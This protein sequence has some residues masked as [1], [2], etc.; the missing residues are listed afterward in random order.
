MVV[1]FENTNN[2]IEVT[3]WYSIVGAP[4]M[5][6]SSYKNKDLLPVVGKI[7]FQDGDATTL[8]LVGRIVKLDGSI[9]ERTMMVPGIYI[10]NQ[11]EWPDWLHDLYKLALADQSASLKVVA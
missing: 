2:K 11:Q 4:V 3:R 1:E 10:W 8:E 9:S 7:T 6:H 5:Q